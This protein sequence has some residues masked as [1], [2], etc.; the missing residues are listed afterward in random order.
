MVLEI[1]QHG[2]HFSVPIKEGEIFI[3]PGGFPHSPQRTEGT[4]GL[5]IERQRHLHELDGLRW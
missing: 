2:K 5:V 4:I 3:L 1:I